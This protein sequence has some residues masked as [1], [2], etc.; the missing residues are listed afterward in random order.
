MTGAINGSCILNEIFRRKSP[1]Q[2]LTFFL[3][4][5][6]IHTLSGT[7]V[8]KPDVFTVDDSM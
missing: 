8:Q 1:I 2:A 5:L 4:T 6:C 3:I 7:E